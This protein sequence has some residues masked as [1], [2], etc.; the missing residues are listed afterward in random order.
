MR[1]IDLEELT[2]RFSLCS[3]PF[4]HDTTYR[5][6]TKIY[7]DRKKK[8][9]IAETI[10]IL[11]RKKEHRFRIEDMGPPGRGIFASF[12]VPASGGGERAETD[13]ER[14]QLYFHAD[15]VDTLFKSE[16]RGVGRKMARWTA[17]GET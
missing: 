14:T 6:I 15:E 1:H 2:C 9:L 13:K 16:W 11:L 4:E 17:A 12:S 8:E 3:P 5:S 7:A 10:S